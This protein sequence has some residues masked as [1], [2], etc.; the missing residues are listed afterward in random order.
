MRLISPSTRTDPDGAFRFRQIEDREHKLS[1]TC[2]LGSPRADA[3]FRTAREGRG[4]RAAGSGRPGEEVVLTL[5]APELLQ[6]TVAGPQGQPVREVEIKAIRSTAKD[7]PFTWM[8]T[9]EE[10]ELKGDEAGRYS[11]ELPRGEWRVR[12]AARAYGFAADQVVNLPGPEVNIELPLLA[13]CSGVVLDEFGAPV[14]GALVRGYT[15]AHGQTHNEDV[16]T[17]AQ[18]QFRILLHPGAGMIHARLAGYAPSEM[19]MIEL[20]GSDDPTELTLRSP[21]KIRC[22]VLD[23]SG[24]PLAGSTLSIADS[25]VLDWP[26]PQTDAAGKALLVDIPPGTHELQ[27][28][29]DKTPVRQTVEVKAGEITDVVFQ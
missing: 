15:R 14:Q 25:H 21:G 11:W 2:G 18:G 9:K 28:Y 8:I 24:K 7:D 26:P 20:D 5:V 12:V 23:G 10:A 22:T 13:P 6:F 16:H 17:D 4:W 1:V 19:H 27:A 3:T 29:K